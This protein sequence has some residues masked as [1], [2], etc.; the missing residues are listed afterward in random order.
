MDLIDAANG[1]M[2]ELPQMIARLWMVEVAITLGVTGL[3]LG[4]SR[5][6][7]KA[8]A[9]LVVALLV[10]AL[11]LGGAYAF[12]QWRRP[13]LIAS[14]QPAISL[15]DKSS[16]SRPARAHRHGSRPKTY[17]IRVLTDPSQNAC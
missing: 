13:H 12:S 17:C 5:G 11:G 10:V 6:V 8:N 14:P 15:A 9:I 16:H 1:L 2:G 7:V 3:A 4:L